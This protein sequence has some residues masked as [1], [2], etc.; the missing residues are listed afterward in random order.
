MLYR[1]L[2]S[3][4]H[5]GVR[6]P[7]DSVISPTWPQA[8]LDRLLEVGVIARVAAPPLTEIPNWKTRAKK[9][10]RHDVTDAEQ[11]LEADDALLAR[12]LGVKPATVERL[13]TEV[14]RWLQPEK[15]EGCCGG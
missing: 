2:R 1:T 9:L 3:L 15:D 8:T 11:F 4:N 6:I 13:K 10:A 5:A 7:R 14:S 12:W